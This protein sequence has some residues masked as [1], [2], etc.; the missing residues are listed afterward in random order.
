MKLGN[1]LRVFQERGREP[2]GKLQLFDNFV[3]RQ[4]F[5]LNGYCGQQLEKQVDTCGKR[6]KKYM[7][8]EP[9]F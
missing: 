2:L 6:K 3:V 8:R 5:V 9:T 4:P 7:L 1:H